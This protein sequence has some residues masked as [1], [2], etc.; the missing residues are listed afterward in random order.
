MQ[1]SRLRGERGNERKKEKRRGWGKH[2]KGEGPTQHRLD[3]R[4]GKKAEPM[5]SSWKLRLERVDAET[6]Q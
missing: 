3:V 2:P 4:R 6:K 1:N 5:G